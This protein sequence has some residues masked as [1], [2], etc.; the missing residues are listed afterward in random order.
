MI[1]DE[2]DGMLVKEFKVGR[3]GEK[4]EREVVTC[5]VEGNLRKNLLNKPVETFVRL[6]YKVYSKRYKQ[7]G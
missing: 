6:S 5:R 4:L 3:F 7:G 1:G 2:S